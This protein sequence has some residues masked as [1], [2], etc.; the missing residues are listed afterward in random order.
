M[1]GSTPKDSMNDLDSGNARR[2]EQTGT[3]GNRLL[4]GSCS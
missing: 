2:M 1:V 3:I 4:S